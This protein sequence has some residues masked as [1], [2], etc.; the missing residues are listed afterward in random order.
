MVMKVIIEL[1]ADKDRHYAKINGTTIT[2]NGNTPEDLSRLWARILNQK[3]YA[4]NDETLEIYCA[5]E[6][7]PEWPRNLLCRG[8]LS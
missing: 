2:S 7:Y 1:E 4:G 5:E 6:Y 3:V 8:I